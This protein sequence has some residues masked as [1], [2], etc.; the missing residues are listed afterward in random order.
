MRRLKKYAY[1]TASLIWMFWIYGFSAETGSVS[2]GK[3][4]NIASAIE[5]I[6]ASLTGGSFS[7]DKEAV[8]FEISHII[9]KSA[10]VVAFLILAMLLFLLIE[11]ILGKKKLF[12]PVFFTVLCA[13]SD[14]FH[15]SL[16]PGRGPSINDVGIDSAGA[17]IGVMLA[18][19]ILTHLR[20]KSGKTELSI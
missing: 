16:V 8:I 13:A 18:F 3:S 15:Q 7:Y 1:G 20:K 11:S 4:M 2:G 12:S 9:R 5:R 10:H 19:L 6:F 14:E 17:L